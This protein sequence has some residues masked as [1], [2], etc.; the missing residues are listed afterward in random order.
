MARRTSLAPFSEEDLTDRPLVLLLLVASVLQTTITYSSE[1]PPC[2]R[3][4]DVITLVS[5]GLPEVV[6]LRAIQ[7]TE[8]AFDI[9]PLELRNL[10]NSGI[11]D[12]LI[13]AMLSVK[14][15][16]SFGD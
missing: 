3:N 7:A 16:N 12:T 13:E 4:E 9:T 15:K 14:L 10:Q 11:S 2:L 1:C 8:N 5:H 6:V